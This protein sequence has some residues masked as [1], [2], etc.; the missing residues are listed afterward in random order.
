MDPAEVKCVSCK[1]VGSYPVKK[2]ISLKA[3]CSSCGYPL[4]EVGRKMVELSNEWS[5][6][7]EKAESEL[8]T[9]EN[10]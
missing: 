3:L 10:K 7:I 9:E 1:K 2:L 5:A 6:F 8:I 4:V